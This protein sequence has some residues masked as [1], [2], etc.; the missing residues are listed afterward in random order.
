[1]NRC[2][3]T[4]S[5]GFVGGRIKA[6]LQR[7]GWQVEGWS[8]RG[9][10]NGTRFSLGQS[11]APATL[12]DVRALVHCAYDFAPASREEIVS[13]NVAG[14]LKLFEAARAAGVERIVFISSLSA[15]PG[16]RS[17]YGRAKLQIEEQAQRLGIWVIRPGLVYGE[18]PGG[19][20]GGLVGQVRR[21]RVMPVLWGGRQ[22]QYLIHEEDLGSL[23]LRM[24]NGSGPARPEP[25]SAA[26]ERG[27]KLGD[28]LRAIE[29]ALGKRV[30]HVPVPW[31]IAWLGL[32]ACE[33]MGVPTPF[34]SD[35]LISLIYQNPKPDFGC[36]KSFGFE[37]RPF[38]VRPEM[39]QER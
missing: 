21:S 28:I 8:R 25:V 15:F 4:G 36:L 18:R 9:D 34:R 24:I 17:E 6:R 16:C 1:M 31:Q 10:P 5:S 2:V 39:L 7:E 38:A 37:C 22:W 20:F 12:K 19:L 13:V 33:A 3:V 35:S 30:V 26:H 23:V 29:R 32:K 27:W 14:S 11:V